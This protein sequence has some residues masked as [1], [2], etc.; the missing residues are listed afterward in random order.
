MDLFELQFHGHDFATTAADLT[1]PQS[2]KRIFKTEVT[3]FIYRWKPQLQLEPS[4]HI[5]NNY[6]YFWPS[7]MTL[8]GGGCASED[9]LAPSLEA[10][11]GPTQ[12]SEQGPTLLC[13]IIC[14]LLIVHY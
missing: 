2:S 10:C 9:I 5:S 3:S 7:C 12:Y 8:F 14:A 11:A 4:I 13:T 1:H 6:F